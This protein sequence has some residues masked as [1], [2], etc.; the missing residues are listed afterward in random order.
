MNQVGLVARLLETPGTVPAS[1]PGPGEDAPDT[2]NWRPSA[3]AA[4]LQDGG[5]AAQPPRYPLEGVT[6]LEF[7]TIIA[8]P[9]ACALLADL[10][11]RVIK[12]E[13]LDGDGLRGLDPGVTVTKTTAGKESITLNLKTGD[14]QEIARRLIE[15]ADILVHNYRPGV[16]ERL[17]LGYE[18]VHAVNP[19]LVYVSATGYGS[20]GPYAMRPSTHPIAGAAVGGAYWQAGAGLPPKE[21]S[22][23]EDIRE[24]A[25]RLTVANEVNPDPSTALVIATAALLGLF[26]QRRQGIGQHVQTNMLGANAWANFDD[27]IRYE[28]KPPRR[29]VDAGLHG[30]HALYRL[31]EAA[32]GWVFL[33]CLFDQ[34]WR[35]FCDAVGRPDLI[36]DARFAGEESRL[37]HDAELAALLCEVFRG[38]SAGEWESLLAAADVACVR[39]DERTPGAFWNED[40]HV[41]QNGF[42]REVEHPA[43]G[44]LR[45]HGPT[46]TFSECEGRFGP[47]TVLDQHTDM[48]LAELGY[49]AADI[50]RFREGG[51]IR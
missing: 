36:E 32:D 18:Q 46:V 23:Y 51:A 8:A 26:A 14:G 37:A 29:Q 17:G 21:I 9:L 15:R 6:V 27:F 24:A 41:R 5:A 22:G 34:E 45:R 11:A 38:R 42:V 30:L 47:G 4:G 50:N 39:A 49:T 1:S 25:R 28:G 48:V 7:A 12:V 20:D 3:P 43:W 44:K 40:P 31:Y 19:G 13:A 2:T 33:A 35:R 10:G 16:P